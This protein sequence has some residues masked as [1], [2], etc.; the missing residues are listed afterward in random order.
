M[1]DSTTII[2]DMLQ[3][4][5]SWDKTWM[6]TQLIMAMAIMALIWRGTQLIIAGAELHFNG[7]LRIG[8]WLRVPTN[9]GQVRHK[10]LK[11]GLFRTYFFNYDN[12][13]LVV[14]SNIKYVKE[15]KEYMSSKP[16][17]IEDDIDKSATHFGL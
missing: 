10:L 8:A 6:L 13:S 1:G 14:K 15:D 7:R 12:Q 3:G 4:G 9:T 5:M 16:D 11:K 2:L 17:G